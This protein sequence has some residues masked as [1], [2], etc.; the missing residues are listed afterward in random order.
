MTAPSPTVDDLAVQ[1]ARLEKTVYDLAAAAAASTDGALQT[2]ADAQAPAALCYP[3]LQ[4][5]VAEF[6]APVFARPLGGE[7]RWCP[8]WWDHVEAALRLEALWRSFEHLRLNGQTGMAV[9]LRDH[10]DHQLPRLMAP[11]GPFAR[12]SP[13][14]PHRPHEPDQTLPVIPPPPGW[15]HDG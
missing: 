11:T 4:T 12:C 7:W 9:W 3:D 6:F 8:Q 14:R 10:L 2:P 1:V 5:W 13:D 15:P